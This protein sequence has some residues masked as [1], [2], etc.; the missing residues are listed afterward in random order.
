[1]SSAGQKRT[2]EDRKEQ[3]RIQNR[4]NQRARRQRLKAEEEANGKTQKHPYRVDRWRLPDPSV[5]A[6][7]KSISSNS[8]SII[9]PDTTR[10]NESQIQGSAAPKSGPSHDFELPL[11]ADHSLIHLISHNVCRGLRSNKFLLRMV[12]NFIN[13]DDK[14]YI[15][16]VRADVYTPCNLAVVRPT[17]QAIPD[18]LVPTQLQ[19]NSPHPTWMD[20]I[21][22]P[23]IRDNLIKRQYLFHHTN[24]LEDLIGDV[25]YLTASEDELT[26]PAPPWTRQGEDGDQ[27]DHD[28]KGL[29]LWGEP[30]LK[31]SW[32]VTS[33]FLGKWAWTTEGC[34][35]IID[36]SNG[37][38]VTRGE[39]P[40]GISV[41]ST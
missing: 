23:R 29:V 4:L 19:M 37:W 14:I 13:V 25:I 6:P 12:A 9:I 22:F 35:E 8:G 39:D 41:S 17:H 11:S 2:A 36:I 10:I 38:R 15:P 32:E 27:T 31:E 16:P 30:H 1:M 34:E 28:T 21:P 3:K 40:L 7:P 20:I 5:S 33:R 24:F 26:L 18:C